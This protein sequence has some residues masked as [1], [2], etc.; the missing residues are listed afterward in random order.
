MSLA[1][2]IRAEAQGSTR[3]GQFTSLLRIAEE[4]SELELTLRVIR[5]EANR[6]EV[7]QTTEVP[8]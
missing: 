1:E 3:P 8:A 7:A 4:V 5:S 2:R 6:V